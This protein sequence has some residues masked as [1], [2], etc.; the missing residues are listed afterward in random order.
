MSLVRLIRTHLGPYRRLLGIVLVLQAIQTAAALTL[1]TL[2]ADIIDNGVLQGDNGYIWRTGAIMLALQLRADRVRR[3]RR[4]LRRTRR[5]ELRARR[6]ARH[7]PAG[8]QLLRP[9]GRPVRRPVADHARHQRRA[10][11]PDARRPRLHDDDRRTDHDGVRH[12]LRDPR[13]RRAVGDHARRHPDPDR[14]ARRDH[15]AD[16][17]DVPADAAPRRPRQRRPPRPDHRHPRG[18]GIRARTGRGRALRRRQRRTDQDIPARRSPDGADVPDR[19]TVH[20]LL[21]RRRA[22]ARGLADR[23]GRDGARLGRSPT[24]AT[25][26][27]CSSRWSC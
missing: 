19:H 8:Q 17:P 18:A 24:S 23:V 10:A 5:D 3:R 25:S 6:A 4:P 7:L 20:Q 11:G 16:G 13:G 12:R 26:C 2:N 27:R 1:P 14:R 9:R 15:H 22:L 21:E